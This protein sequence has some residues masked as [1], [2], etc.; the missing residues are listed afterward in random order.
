ML[1]NQPVSRSVSSRGMKL[2]IL[3]TIFCALLAAIVSAADSRS[4]AETAGGNPNI[5][6]ILADDMGYGDA[7]CYGQK[8]LATPNIDRLAAE[9]MKF[10]RHYAGCTVCA[11]S[12]CVLM[13]GLHTG[14]CRVRG[15]GLGSIPDTDLTVPKLLQGV[16]YTTAGIGKYGLGL[17]LPPDDPRKKGFDYFFGYVD[18]SHAHNC[19]TTFL[20]RNGERV[21]LDNKLLPAR[22]RTTCQA[23]AWPRPTAGNSGLRS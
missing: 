10:T 4:E 9:G 12:R 23:P 3:R 21:P 14:H 7:G 17:P 6:F 16:G 19:Y 11:P 18:T 15:N 2:P 5:I 22:R 1:T 8:T 20:V 13:T